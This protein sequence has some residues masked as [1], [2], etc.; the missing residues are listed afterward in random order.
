MKR[1]KRILVLLAVL[2]VGCIATFALTQ[3]E[4]EQENIRTSDAII[5][6]IPND[7]VTSLSWEY[8]SGSALAFDKID[9]VWQYQDDN[10]F[11]VDEEKVT[12]ILQKFESFGVTFIIEDVEDYAQY[13]LDDPE[14]TL[15][16]TTQENSYDIKLGNFSTMDQQRYVDIGDG[17]VY[18]VSKDPMDYIDE[19]LSSMIDH[20]EIP[21]F[22]TVVS[23]R[24][25]GSESYT[26][27]RIEEST[28]T[29]APADDLY[30]VE[31]DGK[32]VPLDT[33]SVKTYLNTISTLSLSDYVTYNASEEE[34]QT[35]GLDAPTLSVTVDYTHT[36]TDEN[37][38]ETTVSDTCVLH[39][40]E[41]PAERA[42]ADAAI[43]EGESAGSV[44]KYVR[45]GDSQIVYKLSDSNYE[46][47]SSASY[48]DL[49][50]A[51]VFWADFDTVTQIDI[52]L[53]GKAH[54]LISATDEDE[55]RVWYY[56]YEDV[57]VLEDP[58]EI[59]LSELESALLALSAD[60]FT[61]EL[62]TEVEEIGL[63][64]HLDSENFPT[65]SISLYRYD[66]S[67][68]LAVVDG[69]PVSLISRASVMT[70]VE[71]VQTIV[72]NA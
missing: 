38:D 41:N 6:E 43:A 32:N 58:E 55:N 15:H 35:Y 26:I 48:N 39:I 63:T 25:A 71:A 23:I 16:L 57:D 70:L 22:E 45:V 60:S 12:S 17:N 7:T 50:H 40:S 24:F 5:L 36:Q 33:A 49:R 28:D 64:L 65:V 19:E 2:A 42:E 30:F 47:L 3:Y 56:Q 69:T 52:T 51:D 11:P 13:G 21:S 9:G 10:A 34:L 59:S 31:R 1:Y 18:L 68:C 14:A 8:A 66:G 4:Q 61:D 67:F 29:Y 37:G 27:T 54:T 46:T 20:D 72:L 53:E 44:T 62:P